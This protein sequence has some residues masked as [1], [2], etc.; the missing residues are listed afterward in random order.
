[1]TFGYVLTGLRDRSLSGGPRHCVRAPAPPNEL[2]R[3]SMPETAHCEIC[4]SPSNSG[5]CRSGIVRCEQIRGGYRCVSRQ[6]SPAG[7]ALQTRRPRPLTPATDRRVCRGVSTPHRAQ[8][9]SQILTVVSLLSPSGMR[10][11]FGTGAGTT[12]AWVHFLAFDLFVGRWIYLD[13]RG[14]GR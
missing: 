12:L 2:A 8:H 4:A 5:I 13:A 9:V 1:M 10:T 3:V 14:E 7:W 11:L 6:G